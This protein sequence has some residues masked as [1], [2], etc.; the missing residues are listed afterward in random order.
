MILTIRLLYISNLAF[1]MLTDI[2]LYLF[3]FIISVHLS[4]Y[5]NCFKCLLLRN[6]T[7]YITDSKFIFSKKKLA[8]KIRDWDM[9]C[10]RNIYVYYVNLCPSPFKIYGHWKYCKFL[11]QF[12]VIFYIK[13]IFYFL[14]PCLCC[15]KVS[16]L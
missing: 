14:S 15:C 6:R 11:I 1:V 12:E 13:S 10:I 7:L 8:N 16:C 3:L 2:K 5:E 9:F 4:I